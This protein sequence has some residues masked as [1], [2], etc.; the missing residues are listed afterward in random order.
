MFPVLKLG[1]PLIFVKKVEMESARMGIDFMENDRNEHLRITGLINPIQI[2]VLQ[3][4][5]IE[6]T[7]Q[8]YFTVVSDV[9]GDWL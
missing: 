3:T 9:P 8:K 6:Q 1:K 5:E 7:Y 2:I 4:L